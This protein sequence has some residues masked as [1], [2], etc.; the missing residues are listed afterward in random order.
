[1]ESIPNI[2]RITHCIF[3]V[4]D[5]QASRHFYVDLLGL[6]I[7]H[8][9][10]TSL[11]LRGIEDREWTLKLEQASDQENAEPR[12]RQIGYKVW[13]DDELLKLAAIADRQG[14]PYRWE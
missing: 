11:Y 9:S 8:E 13:S 12:A 6:N 7:L 3:T 10:A 5:I 14:L 2:V 1:M 4:R